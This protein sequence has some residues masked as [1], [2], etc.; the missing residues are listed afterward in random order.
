MN[1]DLF[2]LAESVMDILRKQRDGKIVSKEEI[3]SVTKR[4][5]ELLNAPRP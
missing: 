5:E 3:S 1:E 2:V 4:F